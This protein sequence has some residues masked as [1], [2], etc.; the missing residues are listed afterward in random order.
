MMIGD[1][2]FIDG[3]KTAMD[4]AYAVMDSDEIYD[5]L[6]GDGQDDY[7]IACFHRMITEKAW[8]RGIRHKPTATI[9]DAL[10]SQGEG[11]K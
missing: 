10:R 1:A 9:P 5:L 4:D 6:P 11:T 2:D 8:E 7:I 3:Y